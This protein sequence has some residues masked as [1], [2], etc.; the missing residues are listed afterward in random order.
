MNKL[1]LY[2]R[3]SKIHAIKCSKTL[4]EAEAIASFNEATKLKDQLIKLEDEGEYQSLVNN[5]NLWAA[6][7][8]IA[9]DK[10]ISELIN[11]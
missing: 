6:N 3:I 4:K 8:P 2:K 1:D 7:N 10:E 5:I 11:K 9:T